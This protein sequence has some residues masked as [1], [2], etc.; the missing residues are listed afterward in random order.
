MASKKKN[1][2]VCHMGGNADVVGLR[3]AKD[4]NHAMVEESVLCIHTARTT[5]MA[6][7]TKEAGLTTTR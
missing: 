4:G 3:P 6:Q 1:G 7:R 2:S 5:R